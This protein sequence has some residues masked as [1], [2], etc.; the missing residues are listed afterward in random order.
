[1]GPTSRSN[2]DWC[3]FSSISE[4]RT[5]AISEWLKIRDEKNGIVIASNS[6]TNLLIFINIYQLVQNICVG[7]RQADKDTDTIVTS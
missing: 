2:V 5:S 4:V 7:D 3:K 1:M 6:K